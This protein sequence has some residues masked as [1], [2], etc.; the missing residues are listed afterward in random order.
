MCEPLPSDG[1]SLG[2]EG[3]PASHASRFS[4]TEGRMAASTS[5]AR[6][7]V[8]RWRVAR[9]RWGSALIGR[10]VALST[11]G[12]LASRGGGVVCTSRSSAMEVCPASRGGGVIYES[13]PNDGGL[14][15]GVDVAQMSRRLSTKGCSTW[16]GVGA[17]MEGC[18]ASRGGGVRTSRSPAIGS[19]SRRR[20]LSMEG[21]S[22]R[23]GVSAGYEPVPS[24]G[25]SLCLEGRRVVCT[26]RHLS[27]E[28]RL[29]QRAIATSTNQRP[30]M[31]G[32]LAGRAAGSLARP[33][34]IDGVLLGSEDRSARRD[35]SF[36]LLSRCPSMEDV[37]ARRGIGV[38]RI[39][40]GPATEGRSTWKG[41]VSFVRAVD[42]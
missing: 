11:E 21:R 35:V 19:I 34:P 40:R 9:L 31:E 39:G 10:A 42:L 2:M 33:S 12:C 30:A 18:S 6:A 28:G 8:Q 7:V 16:K 27:V 37:S 5:H 36:V 41:V 24:D 14:L 1:G 38:A 23:R 15:G 13:P 32:R 3:R 17:A 26:G 29:A 25:G 22:A 20:R 4:A